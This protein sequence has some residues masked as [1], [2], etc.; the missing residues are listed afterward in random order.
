M[1]SFEKIIGETRGRLRELPEKPFIIGM[2][3][4]LFLV[5]LA[6]CFH[7]FDLTDR[8]W[9]ICGYQQIFAHPESVES[10]FYIYDTLLIGGVW[11][12]LFG[13]LGVIGFNI[14]SVL[15]TLS[16]F[17]IIFS[18]L[19][20]YLN[21]W[22]LFFVFLFSIIG[23]VGVFSYNIASLFF[24][25]L[26]IY[27]IYHALVE[28][29]MWRMSIVGIVLGASLFVRFPNL[30][31]TGL[32]LVLIVY[33]GTT[34][35]GAN[36][37]KLFFSAIGG[38]LIGVGINILLIFAL[39]HT[40]SMQSMME[41][42]TSLL[43]SSD[44]THNMP[45]MLTWYVSLYRMMIKYMY[46]IVFFPC[47]IYVIDRW[48][49]NE[50]VKNILLI[51]CGTVFCLFLVKFF[52]KGTIPMHGFCCL[53]FILVFLRRKTYDVNV[54][55]LA[56][57][58]FLLMWL[59]PM[60]SDGGISATKQSLY[61]ALPFALGIFWNE[62]QKINAKCGQTL[63]MVALGAMCLIIINTTRISLSNAYRDPGSKFHKTAKVTQSYRPTTN[64]DPEK[65]AMLDDLLAHLN[66]LIKEN[67]ELLVYPSLPGIH[68]LTNTTSYLNLP[69]PGIANDAV[70]DMEFEKANKKKSLPL[71]VINK[72]PHGCWYEPLENWESVL[73]CI[74]WQDVTHKNEVMQAFITQYAYTVV[75]NT[76]QFVIYM[77]ASMC[78]YK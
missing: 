33:H 14:L 13:C 35:E 40:A 28:A 29:S 27:Y 15:F 30:A 54:L 32:I 77:P 37:I 20:N 5:A 50:K 75:Y 59:M 36:T 47:I 21:R 8:C 67:T 63:R 74:D 24:A 76:P 1:T 44:S 71:I 64:T 26:S 46:P 38:Y 56:A 52:S 72:A 66:P 4:T 22:V 53:A 60:G 2:F 49:K 55:Y 73:D 34:K 42:T 58:S 68:Y 3:S 18:L 57:L 11:E 65:A 9:V 43:S 78:E 6:Y 51:L 7:G 62:M 31:L 16:S 39:N 17:A 12:Q 25:M 23:Q 19:R 10:M 45:G 70:F 48:E 69:W 41:I 61:F